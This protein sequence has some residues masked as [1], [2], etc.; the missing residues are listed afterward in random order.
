MSNLFAPTFAAYEALG[1]N[2]QMF[3]LALVAIFV[4]LLIGSKFQKSIGFMSVM[5]IL[6]ILCP[7]VYSLVHFNALVQT[8]QEYGELFL[9]VPVG[10]LCAM[11]LC[12][13]LSKTKNREN[14][15]AIFVGVICMIVFCGRFCFFTTDYEKTPNCKSYVDAEMEEIF[16]AIDSNDKNAGVIAPE[17]VMLSAYANDE[18][19]QFAYDIFLMRDKKERE[20]F[21]IKLQELYETTTQ[22][23]LAIGKMTSIAKELGYSHLVIEK[24]EANEY[25]YWGGMG[26]YVFH[27]QWAME[28]GG[29]IP[30]VETN[31]YIVYA[32][33]AYLK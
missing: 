14:R 18:K 2:G 3:V 26:N 20:S 25:E 12:V 11:A 27:E 21:E 24:P 4:L 32:D 19:Y 1:K 28:C 6:C 9:L 33:T 23:E 29:Y 22:N 7:A 10:V 5:L 31:Q 17:R 13:V 15:V 30:V 16:A 8:A